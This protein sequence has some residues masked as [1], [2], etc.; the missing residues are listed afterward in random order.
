M[1][2]FNCIKYDHFFFILSFFPPVVAGEISAGGLWLLPSCVLWE[3]AHAAD[4]WV[5]SKL[6]YPDF[7]PQSMFVQM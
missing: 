1:S 2:K 7:P 6:L 4:R 3:P 5:P